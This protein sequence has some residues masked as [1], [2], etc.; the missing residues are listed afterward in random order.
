M[1]KCFQ[2]CHRSRVF[3][4]P[5]M[6]D[7][8]DKTYKNER[9]I[10]QKRVEKKEKMAREKN[11]ERPWKGVKKELRDKEREKERRKKKEK[12]ISDRCVIEKKKEQN[13]GRKEE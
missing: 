7:V 2:K 5:P 13:K 10:K 12:E 3:I 1:K 8:N 4:A 11:E 6:S 9:K